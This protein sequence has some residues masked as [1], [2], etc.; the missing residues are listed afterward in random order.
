MLINK[1]IFYL[2]KLIVKVDILHLLFIQHIWHIISKVHNGVCIY[3]VVYVSRCSTAFRKM[4][5]C[6]FL[7][8]LR[9]RQQGRHFA[10]N[11]FKHIVL[12]ETV[13]VSEGFYLQSDRIGLMII[14]FIDT[15]MHHSAA[16][17]D[18]IFSFLNALGFVTSVRHSWGHLLHKRYVFD[19]S[20]DI[21]IQGLTWSS[22]DAL[23]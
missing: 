10:D 1:Q 22:R 23:I 17:S 15:Y 7:N 9:P 20:G 2:N 3:R 11:I 18:L 12:N 6:N 8:T 5:R 13:G 21:A 14:W 16:K 4:P 19:C